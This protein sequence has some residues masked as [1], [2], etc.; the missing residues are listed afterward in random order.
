MALTLKRRVMITDRGLRIDDRIE[1]PTGMD[2][3]WM[4]GGQPFS[5]IHMASAGYSQSGRLGTERAGTQ[6]NVQRLASERA[7]DVTTRI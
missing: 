4:S 7:V 3:K 1:N 2:V 6:V 5:S